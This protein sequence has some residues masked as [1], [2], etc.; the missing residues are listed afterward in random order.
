MCRAVDS[1]LNSPKVRRGGAD[2]VKQSD[3]NYD[4]SRKNMTLQG[5]NIFVFPQVRPGGPHGRDP[6]HS[7]PQPSLR[8]NKFSSALKTH[9]I[10]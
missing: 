5:R 1:G 6:Y 4:P 8:E 9:K 10:T 7:G 2:V 3:F